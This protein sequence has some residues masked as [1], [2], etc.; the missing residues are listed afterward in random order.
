MGDV[1]N[2]SGIRRRAVLKATAWSVPVVAAAVA[3]PARAASGDPL[4]DVSWSPVNP[5]NGVRSTLAVAPNKTAPGQAHSFAPGTKVVVTVKN[6]VAD[7]SAAVAPGTVGGATRDA[8]PTV[9]THLIEYVFAVTDLENGMTMVGTGQYGTEYTATVYGPSGAV[10][11]STTSVSPPAPA[12]T[13]T[14]EYTV[15]KSGG[16]S[17][18]Q[19]RTVSIR[20]RGSIRGVLDLTGA[21]VRVTI[22]AGT[23]FSGVGPSGSGTVALAGNVI[24]ISGL[25]GLSAANFVATVKKQSLPVTVAVS[26]TG[27]NGVSGAITG[28]LQLPS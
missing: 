20:V 9:T 18:N 15:G 22:P 28:T 17:A 12:E 16:N 3:V 5:P 1:V 10:L 4:V 24:T 27:V 14:L 21:Q 7:V 13:Y 19:V 2:G 25:G 26:A 23:D 6:P 11:G 8:N